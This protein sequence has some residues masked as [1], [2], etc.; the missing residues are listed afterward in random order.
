MSI[1]GVLDT[2]KLLIIPLDRILFF[3]IEIDQFLFNIFESH[4]QL[5]LF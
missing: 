1:N 2:N 3:R 4:F 5:T